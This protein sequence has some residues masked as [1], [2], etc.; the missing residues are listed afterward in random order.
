MF[1]NFEKTNYIPGKN[2]QYVS[3]KESH[4]GLKELIQVNKTIQKL[5]KRFNWKHYKR[6]A[7]N[8]LEPHENMP[9][10]QPFG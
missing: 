3:D 10:H 8:S 1:K 9:Y 2:Q 6:R 5:C 4:A 7:I